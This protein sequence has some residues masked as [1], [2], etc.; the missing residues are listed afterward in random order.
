MSSVLNLN[1]LLSYTV[2]MLSVLE[3]ELNKYFAGT[4]GE[5]LLR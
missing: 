2:Y 5:H 4:V 1:L 3:R